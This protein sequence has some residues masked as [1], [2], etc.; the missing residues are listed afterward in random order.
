MSFEDFEIGDLSFSEALDIISRYEDSIQRDPSGRWTR[1]DLATGQISP[2]RASGEASYLDYAKK[3][4]EYLFAGEEIERNLNGH[5]SRYDSV[6]FRK[7]TPQILQDLGCKNLPMLHTQS[8]LIQETSPKS[9]Q[10]FHLHG[11]T[12]TLIKEIPEL[13]E[14]PVVVA[15]NLKRPDGMVT[16]LDKTDPDG[17][18]MLLAFNP[19]GS[20]FW[21]GQRIDS[22]F[23]LTMFGKDG[24]NLYLNNLAV[25]EKL[26]YV[27]NKKLVRLLQTPGHQSPRLYKSLNGIIRH[28]SPSTQAPQHTRNFNP[29]PQV[30]GQSGHSSPQLD[31]SDKA[32]YAQMAAKATKDKAQTEPQ[33]RP[34]QAQEPKQQDR[35]RKSRSAR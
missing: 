33:P 9:I 20:G 14:S 31:E 10:N 18:P 23:I 11:L 15:D 27:D 28:Y 8:H 22:N 16:V 13:L 6:M 7:D 26:L 29:N 34:E 32:F 30:R 35:P 2:A 25:S 3:C 5:S 17:L 12:P 19:D 1:H 4:V 24:I 21:R